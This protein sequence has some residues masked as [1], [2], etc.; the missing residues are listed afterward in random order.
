[1]NVVHLRNRTSMWNSISNICMQ[2]LMRN[3]SMKS[4]ITSNHFILQRIACSFKCT[5][6][7]HTKGS[8]L[9]WCYQLSTAARLWHV[10]ICWKER[11]AWKNSAS[12]CMFSAFKLWKTASSWAISYPMTLVETTRKIFFNWS[13]WRCFT[14]KCH[15]LNCWLCW[16]WWLVLVGSTGIS[17][18]SC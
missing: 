18:S 1:M 2:S 3:M 15:L 17:K 7:K 5:P 16:W 6:S 11:T 9:E 13:L 12:S 8:M 10:V 14:R 4:A